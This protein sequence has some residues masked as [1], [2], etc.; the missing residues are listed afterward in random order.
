[1]TKDTP[2]WMTKPYKALGSHCEA[3]VVIA[4]G[5]LAFRFGPMSLPDGAA[6]LGQCVKEGIPG[7]ALV[8]N[9]GPEFDME[10]A[11]DLRG[12][13]ESLPWWKRKLWHWFYPTQKTPVGVS[14]AAPAEKQT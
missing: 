6:L 13:I 11:S 10:F 12:E 9:C 8:T 5:R 3:W 4:R 2:E 14:P 1:M 7:A